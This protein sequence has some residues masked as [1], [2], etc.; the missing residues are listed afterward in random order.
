[1]V[2]P[3]NKKCFGVVQRLLVL[4]FLMACFVEE[5]AVGGWVDS[6][7]GCNG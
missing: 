1:M 5:H 4:V 2:A 6:V 7:E 3:M